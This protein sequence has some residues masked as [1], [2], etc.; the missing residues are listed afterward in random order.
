M[1]TLRFKAIENLNVFDLKPFKVEKKLSEYFCEN[2]F[3]IDTMR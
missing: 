2:V 3:N 1:S